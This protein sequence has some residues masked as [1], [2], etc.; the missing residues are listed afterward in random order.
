MRAIGHGSA[1]ASS[2]TEAVLGCAPDMAVPVRDAA[3]VML[4]R[5]GPDGVEV[6]MLER[7]SRLG[8]LGG[9]HVFPGGAV[10]EADSAEE[11]DAR[12]S[13]FESR[14]AAQRLGAG[15]DS[16]ARGFYVAALRELFEEAG[17]LL[18]RTPGG[19]VIDPE[20]RDEMRGRLVGYRQEL[21]QGEAEFAAL[22]AD[23]GLALDCDALSYLGHWVTPEPSPKR[24]DTRFFIARMPEAQRA[25]QVHGE[26]TAEVW[27]RPRAALDAFAS[28]EI[29]MVPPTICSLDWLDLHPTV[30]SAMTAAE[31]L[32]VVTVQPRIAVRDGDLTLLYDDDEGYEGHWARQVE[33][34]RM[35]ERRVLRDGTWVKPRR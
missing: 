28:G 30:E 11:L 22:L 4:V 25:Q 35:L 2:H 12:L 19:P 5:D 17:I 29:Q 24:F 31:Q 34:G 10:D 27:L 33:S 18:A 15:D 6:Y 23:E 32:E 1:A 13:G 9:A 8:F 14:E 26:L 16:R 20:G 21:L 7:N 3:T